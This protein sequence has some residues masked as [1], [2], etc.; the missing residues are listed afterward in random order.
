MPAFS[1]LK[2]K[3]WAEV[4]ID[5]KETRNH[6]MKLERGGSVMLEK[7]LSF[8]TNLYK[9]LDALLITNQDG[10]IEYS[11]RFD[12][13]SNNII[14]EGYTGK[15]I[16]EIYPELTKETSTCYRAIRTGRPVVDEVQTLIDL[17]GQ[18]FTFKTSTYPLEYNGE[19]I[20]AIEGTIILAVDGRPVTK[21]PEKILLE[22]NRKSLY[23]LDSI[24]TVDEKMLMI[25]DRVKK[26]AQSD[27]SVMIIGETGTGKELIAQSLHTHSLRSKEAFVSQNCGAI[28]PNLLESVLFGTVKGAYT[29]AENRRGIFEIAHK[30]TL[31]LDELNSLDI[32][33]Q[34]KLLKAIEDQKIRRIGGETE[35]PIDVRIVSAIN[36]KPFEAIES[37]RL[38]N[39]LFFR[40]GIIQI[41]LPPLRNRKEDILFL[42]EYFMNYFN[43]KN[44]TKVKKIS[45]LVEKTFLN[46]SWFGNIRE[47]R[48][49]IES[50]LCMTT[51][52]TISVN[53]LPEYML[54]SSSQKVKYP[55]DEIQTSLTEAIELYEK[56]VLIKAI[57]SGR[58]LTEIARKLKIS[59]QVLQY[60]MTKHKLE[61][62]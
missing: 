1:S 24:I 29:G 48:N 55:S 21:K 50:A 12:Q 61:I 2:G 10:V 26:V 13:E 16:L 38:R 25:K 39:D 58:T 60:K 34:G 27:V 11:V 54:Y 36:Q 8:M 3:T 40:L 44:A 14:N 52:E 35:I 51:S 23:T 28:P 17:N 7:Y 15:S 6:F 37:G 33:L 20:G 32:S 46:Y 59:R 49:V 4:E 53:D 18:S 47:L 41:D 9:N 31:F 43:Q 22:K 5:Q 19:I 45:A 57:E 42:A 62:E 56:Q 30:G